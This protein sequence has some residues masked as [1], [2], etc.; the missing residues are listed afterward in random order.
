MKLQKKI[1]AEEL[2]YDG[3]VKYGLAFE[4]GDQKVEG[5]TGGMRQEQERVARLE[6]KVKQLESHK[7]SKKNCHTC[8]RGTHKGKCPGLEMTC[9][10]CHKEGHMKGS[11]ACKGPK[12]GKGKHAKSGKR[13]RPS[14]PPGRWRKKRS[15]RTTLTVRSPTG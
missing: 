12:A 3:V 13:R 5:Q 11:R 1:I 4:Q 9:F 14:P 7:G 6:N 15:R 2:G 8:I 10:S